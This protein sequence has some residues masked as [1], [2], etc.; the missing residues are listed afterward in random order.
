MNK[1]KRVVGCEMAGVHWTP[2]IY[3]GV[4]IKE[5]EI[6]CHCM[7]IWAVGCWTMSVLFG[8]DSRN[9][10]QNPAVRA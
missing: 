7:G 8:Y 10:A 5:L 3:A 6:S 1:F 9:N 4:L 2:L